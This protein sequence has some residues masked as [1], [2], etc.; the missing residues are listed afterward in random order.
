[1]GV[2][3]PEGLGETVVVDGR[4]VAQQ[5]L[6]PPEYPSSGVDQRRGGVNQ[7]RDSKVL[8]PSA[9]RSMYWRPYSYECE[10]SVPSWNSFHVS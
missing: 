8:D 5:D 7:G 2:E 9:A 3:E 1:V 10:M 4:D 6:V